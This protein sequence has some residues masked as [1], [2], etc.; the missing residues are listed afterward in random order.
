MYELII[1]TLLIVAK[2]MWACP[3]CD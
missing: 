3:G 2:D 1:Y